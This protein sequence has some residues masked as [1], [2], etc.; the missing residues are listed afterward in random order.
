MEDDVMIHRAEPRVK[1]FRRWAPGDGRQHFQRERFRAADGYPILREA[2]AAIFPGRS[3]RSVSGNHHRGNVPAVESLLPL[4]QTEEF[5]AY[6]EFPAFPFF[7]VDCEVEGFDLF[8][9]IEVGAVD[10]DF[11][12]ENQ[13][14]HDRA[15]IR[16]SFREVVPELECENAGRAGSEGKRVVQQF[17]RREFHRERHFQCVELDELD[18]PEL[19]FSAAVGAEGDCQV[20]RSRGD[21]EFIIVRMPLRTAG[22]LTVD[23]AARLFSPPGPRI[24]PVVEIEQN[25]LVVTVVSDDLIAAFESQAEGAARF[26]RQCHR[27]IDCD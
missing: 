4:E 19:N 16:R 14:H 24:A 11:R 17:H 15:G 25:H 2:I 7:S 18:V 23:V 3:R 9:Q 8:S 27:L 10:G 20:A 21:V 12:G 6:F 13:I 5:S 1:L 26:I 22:D